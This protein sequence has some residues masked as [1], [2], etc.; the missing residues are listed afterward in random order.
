MNVTGLAVF[1]AATRC[2]LAARDPSTEPGMFAAAI[3]EGLA[4]AA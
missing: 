4:L 1:D 3:S 2:V